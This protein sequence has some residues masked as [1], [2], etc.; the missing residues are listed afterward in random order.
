MLRTA[1]DKER[2]AGVTWRGAV[3]FGVF[4]FLLDELSFWFSLSGEGRVSSSLSLG[5][6]PVRA[7][8]MK[9][10]GVCLGSEFRV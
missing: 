2:L 7:R 8:T 5:T 4:A 1:I 10:G 6:E 3:G 9:L